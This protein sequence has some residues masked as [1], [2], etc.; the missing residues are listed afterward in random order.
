[1]TNK[2]LYLSDLI[3]DLQRK[4]NS[5]LVDEGCIRLDGARSATLVT[6]MGK[7]ADHARNLE[8]HLSLTELNR[9]AFADRE[10]LI[11]NMTATT[12][13]VLELMR[14]DRDDDKIVQFR[15]KPR[16]AHG[17]SVPPGGDAA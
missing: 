8:S 2:P 14:D 7:L 6:T 11:A 3:S 4:L 13:K 5:V 10:Q 16:H 1:M 12:A 9:R 15:P 17:P